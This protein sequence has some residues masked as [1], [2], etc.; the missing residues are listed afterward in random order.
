MAT[1]TYGYTTAGWCGNCGRKRGP[2]G[3]C[4][5]CDPWWTSPIVQIGGPIALLVSLGLIVGISVF[6][7]GQSSGPRIAATMINTP[8]AANRI[9]SNIPA[10]TY[11]ANRISAPVISAP[12]I[13]GNYARTP[14]PEEIAL[15]ELSELRRTTA[16]VDSMVQAD[17]NMRAQQARSV[18]TYPVPRARAMQM[19]APEMAR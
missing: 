17:Q 6:K 15:Q 4:A 18:S 16:Y 13:T 9:S 11:S 10:T 3:R 5:N 1:G 8:I 14:R 19:G 7:G 12:A 2:D